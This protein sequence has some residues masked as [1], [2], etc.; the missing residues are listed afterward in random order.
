MRYLLICFVLFALTQCSTPPQ[1]TVNPLDFIPAKPLAIL[2]TED[3][4]SLVEFSNSQPQLRRFLDPLV[5]SKKHWLPFQECIVSFHEEGVEEHKYLLI[6]PLD[7]LDSIPELVGDTLRYENLP[8]IRFEKQSIDRYAVVHQNTYFESDSKIL[9]ENSIRL[10]TI[11]NRPDENLQKLYNSKAGPFQL[12]INERSQTLL[13]EKFKTSIPFNLSDFSS[14]VAIRPEI[15]NGNTI[16]NAIALLSTEKLTKVSLVTNQ[17]HDLSKLV[18]NLPLTMSGASLYGFDA[19]RFSVVRDRYNAQQNLPSPP[20][21]SFLMQAHAVAK[22]HTLKNQIAVLDMTGV[23]GIVDILEKN[24]E[25]TLKSRDVMTYQFSK[26]KSIQR[27]GAPL[28]NLP[29]LTHAFL[30]NDLLFLAP[31][32]ASL[33][34]V[35]TQLSN[36]YSLDSDEQFAG[37]LEEIPNESSLLFVGVEEFFSKQLNSLLIDDLR[38]DTKRKFH[39][40]LGVGLVESGVAQIQF[41]RVF[42]EEKIKNKRPKLLFST[43][44]ESTISQGP[45]AVRNHLNGS[46][47]WVVQ[48][49]KHNLILIS[50]SGKST[51]TRPIG[52]PIQFPIRQIDLYK[53]S[54]LQMAYNTENGFEVIDRNARPVPPFSS[55]LNNPLPLA[56]FDYESSRDY[57]LV[58]IDQNK[59][60]LR[61]RKFVKV[62]GFKRTKAN[63]KYS[64]KHIRIGTRDYITMVEK[65]GKLLLLDRRG[66]VRIKTPNDLV[67]SSDVYLHQNGFVGLDNKNR[68]FRIEINGKI[69]YRT[70]P[71]ETPYQVRARGKNLVLLNENKLE[72]NGRLLELDFGL[73]GEPSIHLV[74]NRTLISLVDEQEEKVYVFDRKGNLLPHFPIYGA[75]SVTIDSDRKG[76]VFLATTGENNSLVVYQ[77]PQ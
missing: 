33:T 52:S 27:L 20:I 10:H 50:R 26:Q 44:I 69:S 8:I 72:I 51:W 48:D 55:T 45:N 73:Y 58:L 63:L 49:E 42:K 66:N 56:V 11:P 13:T 24:A 75:G 28:L 19:D 47:E 60:E 17:S 3:M 65:S 37:L 12:F 40:W 64:P 25:T 41:Q 32:D 74:N 29:T 67:M 14:W 9:L 61:D 62:S 68:L 21:N 54:R 23:E 76:K 22:V 15:E 71:F 46:M 59:L 30:L 57:R 77:I 6:R 16:L 5:S 18:S 53:N 34:E 36:G 31:S 7:P 35:L 38:M 4:E 2:H 1:T 43:P 70:L 39:F